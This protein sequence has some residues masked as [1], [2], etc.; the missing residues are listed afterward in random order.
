MLSSTSTDVLLLG[1]AASPD[2]RDRALM[3]YRLLKRSTQEAHDI[4]LVGE[5]AT[6][7]NYYHSV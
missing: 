2:V 5:E 1:P 3:Y 4:V 7:S 6:V